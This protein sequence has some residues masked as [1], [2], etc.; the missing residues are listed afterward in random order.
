MSRVDYWVSETA[1]DTSLLLLTETALYA[2]R[3]EPRRIAEITQRIDAGDLEALPFD[4][5]EVGL[6]E[7]TQ[8]T[9]RARSPF[10]VCCVG[11]GK[12]AQE[13]GVMMESPTARDE[14]IE[15]LSARLRWPIQT[16]KPGPF[17]NFMFGISLLF[18][19]GVF[20]TI[21]YHAATA[22]RPL[23]PP[24]G[25]GAYLIEFARWIG[26]TL[27]PTGVVILGTIVALTSLWILI[28]SFIRPT[29]TLILRPVGGPRHASRS[30]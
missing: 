25:Q 17:K 21:A 4:F 28:Q 11:Y 22:T 14:L 6:D 16:E 5:N 7:L 9:S 12:K 2:G 23:R 26:R 10:V 19:D 18:L 24:H 29:K 30:S 1:G 13:Y 20:S 3:A 27:G 15:A 8:V